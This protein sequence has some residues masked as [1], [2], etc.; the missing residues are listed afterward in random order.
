MGHGAA[1]FACFLCRF[2]C[3]PACLFGLVCEQARTA[4]CPVDCFTLACLR[5]AF[6][7]R[8]A[9]IHHLAGATR[10]LTSPTHGML[11]IGAKA[12]NSM[13]MPRHRFQTC[14]SAP[15][16]LHALF[17][18]VHTDAFPPAGPNGIV[19]RR[20]SNGMRLNYR[21]T[22]NEPRAALLRIIAPGGSCMDKMGP[23]GWRLELTCLRDFALDFAGILQLP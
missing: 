19:Q 4:D 17:P 12:A 3:A 1:F 9:F 11:S 23:G 14:D 10:A 13:H 15:C 2:D 8:C 21:V 22:D 5:C 18:G 6:M 7:C 16:S 20:L